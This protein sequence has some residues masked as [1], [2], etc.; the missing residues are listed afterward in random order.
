MY[1]FG[2]GLN[3]NPDIL[4]TMGLANVFL[5]DQVLE[6]N[7]C[8]CGEEMQE[9]SNVYVCGNCSKRRDVPTSEERSQSSRTV[10]VGSG[11]KRRL[12]NIPANPYETKRLAVLNELRARNHAVLPILCI[13]DD[14]LVL[15]AEHYSDA[16]KNNKCT[17]VHSE[18]EEPLGEAAWVHRGSI[19]DEI[20]AALIYFTAHTLGVAKKKRDIAKFM[21]L[22]N[23]GFSRGEDMVRKL[24]SQQ[25]INVQI[26]IETPN[27]FAVRYLEALGLEHDWHVDFVVEV[28]EYAANSHWCLNCQLSSR[29]AGAIWMLVH[30]VPLNRLAGQR[31]TDDQIEKHTDNTKKN[32]FRKIIDVVV[33]NNDRFKHIFEKYNVAF[34]APLRSRAKKK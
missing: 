30:G 26:D 5:E 6:E 31:I 28:V 12:Y 2:D 11:A 22:Q 23:E 10:V 20:L 15:V 14:I 4:E 29:V 17:I 27:I 24:V 13:S 8:E 33:Q 21:N 32:T 18:T 19:K 9:I 1:A 16:Q 7:I 34:P 3:I 25:V